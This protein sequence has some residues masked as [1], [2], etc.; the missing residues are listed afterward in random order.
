M[1]GTVIPAALAAALVTSG[2]GEAPADTA[3]AVNVSAGATP[4]SASSS[5]ADCANGALLP[6]TGLC[7]NA[8]RSLFLA[9]DDTIETFATR[10]LWRTEEVQLSP[11]D[12]L[13][14]RTQDCSPEGWVRTVYSHVSDYLKYRMDGTPEDQARFALQI[15]PLSAGETPEDAAMKT[16]D[17]APEDQRSRC[18]VVKLEGLKLTGE[19][20]RLEPGPALKAELEALSG[21]EPYDACGP[22]G[23]TMDAVQ[24]WEG[25][26]KVALFHML[27][28]DTPPWDPTSFTFYHRAADGRWAK[29]G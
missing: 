1:R 8:D 5:A 15:V 10:C 27:G 9:T 18:H 24:F 17:Q 3:S 22:N 21:G 2:C 25:R 19:T 4:A 20:F 29:V 12:A 23:F 14:F 26:P 16:L 7:N 6:V 13:V 11:D 28:Q